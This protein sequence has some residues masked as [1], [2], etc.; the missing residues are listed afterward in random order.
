MSL[1]A[2]ESVEFETNLVLEQQ[3]GDWEIVEEKSK[4]SASGAGD[5]HVSG[6]SPLNKT[7]STFLEHPSDQGGYVSLRTLDF[8][9]GVATIHFTRPATASAPE[10]LEC[11]FVALAAFMDCLA[12]IDPKLTPPAPEECTITFKPGNQAFTANS[13]TNWSQSGSCGTD[14]LQANCTLSYTPGL[15]EAVI[16]APEDLKNWLPAGSQVPDKPGNTLDLRVELRHRGEKQPAAD[17]T[18]TFYVTLEDVSRQPGYCV[19]A[20][21]KDKASKDPDLKLRETAN[22]LLNDGQSGQTEEDANELSLTL[23]SHDFGSYGRLRVEVVV[24]DGS[25]I[26]AHLESDPGRDYLDLPVDEN[27]NHIAD[28][29]EREKGVEEFPATW[30]EADQPAGQYEPGD[31]ISLYEKYRGFVLQGFHQRLEPRKKHLFLHDP[32]GL[33]QL[34]LGDPTGVNFAA[35]LDCEVLFVTDGNWTGPGSSGNGKRVVN[36]NSTEEVHAVDQHALHLRFPFTDTPTLPSDY[37]EL[38]RA[39]HGTNDTETLEGTFGCQYPDL[40]ARKKSPVGALVIETYANNIEAY[41]RDVVQYHTWAAPEFSGYW[42]PATTA[43]QR[44]QMRIRCR[45]LAAA[46][47]RDHRDDF[48]RRNW[49]HFTRTL[50]HEIG[51]GIGVDDLSIP[52]N[53]GPIECVMRYFRLE[54]SPRNVSDRFE[55]GS[56]NPWPS[57]YCQSTVGTVEGISC[58][59]QIQI[60]DRVGPAQ[61]ASLAHTIARPN[62]TPRLRQGLAGPDPTVHLVEAYPTLQLSCALLWEDPLAGDP[63][64]VEVTLSSAAYQQALRKA[65]LTG[66]GVPPGLLHPTPATNWHEGV[67]LT[68]WRHGQGALKEVLAREAWKPHLR[69]QSVSPL[70]FGKKPVAVSRE[71]LASSTALN[72]APG[73]YSLSV[74]WDGDDRVEDEALDGDGYLSTPTLRFTVK[75]VDDDIRRAVQGHRLAFHAYTVGDTE[76]AFQLAQAALA[77]PGAQGVLGSEGTPI[78]A[79]NA[80]L[81]LGRYREAAALLQSAETWLHGELAMVAQDFR[82]VLSPEIELSPADVPGGPPRLTLTGLPDQTYEIESSADLVRWTSIDHRRT[83]TNRYEVTDFTAPAVGGARFYRAVWLP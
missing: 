28:A 66:T 36:F 72:L 59:G 70:T 49:L 31:G 52:R 71:W 6:E 5:Y 1:A 21:S 37:Q 9:G 33:A 80:A 12:T 26:K 62:P 65:A 22:L 34:T 8:D 39:K 7:V 40:G 23:E 14:T 55:F 45:D 77:L 54:D 53:V 69:P 50:T 18:G 25:V 35:A 75:P 44:T 2:Q 58:W 63:M 48:E 16:L 29:W 76:K 64:R 46:Y 68:L 10:C 30:D 15:W 67:V 43:G 20:P 24:N 78:L 79:A 11:G 38:Y 4:A 32:T 83:E 27:R 74:L 73:E 82:Q 60:T 57:I 47:I 13:S 42:D 56:R 81:K 19:N 51:H 17:M 41:T 61:S 3:D